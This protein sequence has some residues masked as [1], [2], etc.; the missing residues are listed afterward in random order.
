MTL[1]AAAQLVVDDQGRPVVGPL[2]TMVGL[3]GWRERIATALPLNHAGGP[4]L[5]SR[6]GVVVDT[7][8]ATVADTAGDPVAGPTVW[9]HRFLP[10]R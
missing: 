8:A 1:S 9:V 10:A 2:A 3:V 7:A 6:N 4:V 5:L